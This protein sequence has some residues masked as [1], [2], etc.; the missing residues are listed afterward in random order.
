[1]DLEEHTVACP[2]CGEPIML[3]ADPSAGDQR[4]IED[5]SVCCQPMAVTVIADGAGD[6]ADVLV[7][8]E[9]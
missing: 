5:C 4:Y 2:Y 8:R 6:V 7:E 1:M 3:L 9:D